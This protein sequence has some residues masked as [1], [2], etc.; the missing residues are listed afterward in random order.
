MEFLMKKAQEKF[1]GLDYKIYT[2]RNDFFGETIT[3]AG[4]LTGRDIIVQLKGK[5]L[6]GHLLLPASVL[7]NEADLFLD[8]TKPDDLERAVGVPVSYVSSDGYELF[9][10]IISL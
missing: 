4:L 9:D 1:P 7:R 5:D 10:S 3:V 2:I 6:K 8:D